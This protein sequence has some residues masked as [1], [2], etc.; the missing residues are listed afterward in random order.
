MI[1][2]AIYQSGFAIS[3][4]GDTLE[5]A[6]ED[7]RPWLDDPLRDLERL[8]V[9]GRESGR[10]EIHGALYARPCTARLAAMVREEGGDL[11]YDVNDNGELDIDDTD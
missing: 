7:A 2:F 11:A 10:G 5:A 4:V 6:Q 1:M 9:V 3:G 8:I